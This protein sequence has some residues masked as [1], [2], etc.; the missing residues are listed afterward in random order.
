[1]KNLIRFSLM[2][3]MAITA[4]AADVT[5]KWVASY[6]GPN[7]NKMES[8]FDLKTEGTALTG[9]VTSPRGEA[10]IQ[11]GKVD[12]DNVSFVVIRNF[13]G[14]EVKQNYTGKVAGDEMKLSASFGERTIEMTAKR[15]K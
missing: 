10:K 4:Y 5:G 1:M 11:E 7:G 15:S 6:E 14:N 8:T 12:G 2:A 3:V 13:Q 9:T